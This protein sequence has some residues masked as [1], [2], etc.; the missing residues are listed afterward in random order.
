VSTSAS[1]SL[2][3]SAPPRIDKTLIV[4]EVLA[5]RSEYRRGVGPKLKGD[6]S[7]SSTAASPPRDP[8]MPDSELQDFFSQT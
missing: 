3:Q 6:T 7:I 1:S 5:V 2:T 8:P 4:D